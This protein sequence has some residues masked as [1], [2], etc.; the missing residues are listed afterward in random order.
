MGRKDEKKYKKYAYYSIIKYSGTN[1]NY[2][3]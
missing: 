3:H 2:V 1:I